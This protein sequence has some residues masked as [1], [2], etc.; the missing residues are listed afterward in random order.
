MNPIT[1]LWRRLFRPAPTPLQFDPLVAEPVAP[2][3]HKKK[4]TWSRLLTI[5]GGDEDSPRTRVEYRR[6]KFLPGVL[7]GLWWPRYTAQ[8]QATSERDILYQDAYNFY[9]NLVWCHALAEN[10]GISPMLTAAA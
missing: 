9:T 6:P 3:T 4:G 2:V 7:M 10:V 8:G 1:K 5:L